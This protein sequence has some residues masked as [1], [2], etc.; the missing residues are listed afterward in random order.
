MNPE[1][2]PFPLPPW[3]WS[4]TEREPLRESLGRA[5]WLLI[6]YWLLLVSGYIALTVTVLGLDVGGGHVFLAVLAL[7]SV[8]GVFV[9]NLVGLLRL[10]AWPLN[11]LAF[12]ASYGAC[13]LAPFIGGEA[14][15]VLVTLCWSLG[16]GHLTLQR[17][18][19]LA[20]L[21]IPIVCWTGAIVTM[22]NHSNRLATWEQGNKHAVWQPLTAA[23]LFTA[24]A[25]VFFFFA[26]QEHYHLKVW[27]AHGAN[28]S[29]NVTQHKG[30]GARLTPKGTIALLLMAALVCGAVAVISPYLWRTRVEPG[31]DHRDPQEEPER[32][33]ER[34]RERRDPGGDFDWDQ[35]AQQARRAAREAEREA[36]DILPFVPLF[37]LNR[38]LRR[39]ILLRHLRRPL[40]PVSP[41]QRALNLWR[42]VLIA[43]GDARAMPRRGESLEALIE[44]IERERKRPVEGLREAADLHQRIRFGLGIPEGSMATFEAHARNALRDLRKGLTAWRKIATWWRKIDV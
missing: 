13:W 8:V 29:A 14:T 24:V 4:G 37:L 20:T 39:L 11:A 35:L 28:A 12:L 36:K 44:R 2:R 25:L 1:L 7:V 38:P 32:R 23:L 21:W 40:F 19:S 26:G 3:L 30:G 22:I 6:A 42:Y 17:R 27:Q 43:L 15:A 16:C 34:D 31:R 5:R 18:F 33:P 41:T 10:R 9:G